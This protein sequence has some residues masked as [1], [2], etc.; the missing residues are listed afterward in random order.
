M[1]RRL[2]KKDKELLQ[3]YHKVKTEQFD[4]ERIES[5]HVKCSNDDFQISEQTFEDLSFDE[6]F[7]FL[8]RTISKI[9]QQH[10][11]NS[12]QSTRLSPKTVERETLIKKFN[13]EIN[14][15]NDTILALSELSA[16]ESYYVTTLLSEE[17]LKKPKWFWAIQLASLISCV[18]ILLAIFF[19][20]MWIIMMF[21]LLLNFIIHYWNKQ[22]ILQYSSSLPQLLRMLD[23]CKKLRK[24]TKNDSYEVRVAV[25]NLE[26]L[27]GKIVI[28][29]F[30]PGLNSDIGEIADYLLEILRALFLIEPLVLFG[31][32]NRLENQKAYIREVFE[33]I[34]EI[35]VALN[36]D[37]IRKTSTTTC[38]PSFHS[39]INIQCSEVYH[40]LIL[41][42][43]A[44]SID[45]KTESIL[46]TGSNMSG[47][48][49]FLRVLGINAILGQ[50]INICFAKAFRM[51]HMQV[52]SAIKIS[53]DL[54]NDRSYYFQEVITIRQLLK[55]AEND[56]PNMF[57]LDELFKGTNT[58]ER[59]ASGKAVLSELARN[60]NIVL[61]ATHD[62][63]LVHLLA[64]DY[65]P[66]HFSEEIKGQEVYFDYKLKK[67]IL[68]HTNAINILELNEY[69]PEVVKEAKTIARQLRKK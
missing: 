61:I 60:G 49:T 50:S 46:L 68:D 17:Y 54:M 10:F 51:P 9:G 3:N 63:E 57:L 48:T 20:V 19:P 41:E 12:F 55:A 53:D 66:Y 14:L 43:V 1:A 2:S 4:F 47:K 24:L 29:R 26:K 69:P 45:I 37:S 30:N 64:S 6:L 56:Q 31:I 32:L 25:D 52:H 27:R 18:T 16:Y 39:D 58:I 5:H 22:N 62:L 67:G 40:P 34:G 38:Q 59:I 28:F 44:N 36:I 23:T 11:F 8:D 65:V 42:P 15:K 7:M 33:F 13:A 21:V 35:D